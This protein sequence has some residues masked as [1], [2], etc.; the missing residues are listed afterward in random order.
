MENQSNNSSLVNVVSAKK[1]YTTMLCNTLVNPIH[2]SF[3]KMYQKNKDDLKK[4]QKSLSQI[5]KWKSAKQA[6]AYQYIVD[7]CKCAWLEELI[8]AVFVCYIKIM[9]EVRYNYSSFPP[10]R[11]EMNL[12]KGEEFLHKCFIQCARGFWEN[13]YLFQQTGVS[14]FQ[15]QQ[16]LKKVKKLIKKAIEQT[17]H[18][19]LPV[20]DILQT[21]LGNIDVLQDGDAWSVVSDLC[22]DHNRQDVNKSFKKVLES[23]NDEEDRVSVSLDDKSVASI[24]MPVPKPE[25]NLKDGLVKRKKPVESRVLDH[26]KQN[27]NED[28]SEQVSKEDSDDD[29]D[30][31]L[32][33]LVKSDK[34][35]YGKKKLLENKLNTY[36]KQND[37]EESNKDQQDED[38]DFNALLSDGMDPIDALNIGESF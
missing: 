12:P 25:L 30:V 37:E 7:T 11:L 38:D 2:A 1:E 13:P 28:V 20:K 16:N 32:S 34:K 29:D 9:S 23:L 33:D 4:F 36:D 8:A 14:S 18:K 31:N 27:Q 17:I 6:D 10:P 5:P 26:I 24:P 22:I 21:Y 3:V 35:K 19:L 15:K